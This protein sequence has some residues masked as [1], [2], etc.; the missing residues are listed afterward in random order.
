MLALATGEKNAP[1]IL[2][3][4]IWLFLPFQLPEL[5][6]FGS[7]GRRHTKSTTC[8]NL[9]RHIFYERN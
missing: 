9:T 7:K 3:L 8:K 2:K 6:L 1:K 5:V 4:L